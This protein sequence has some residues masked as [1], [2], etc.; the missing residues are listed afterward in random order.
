MPAIAGKAALDRVVIHFAA[1]VFLLK[2]FQPSLKP[3]LVAGAQSADHLARIRQI[4]PP[5]EIVHP[6]GHRE[7]LRLFVKLQFQP[8]L[9]KRP[10]FRK[11]GFQVFLVLMQQNQEKEIGS[12]PL[13]VH[14]RVIHNELYRK[15][16]PKARPKSKAQKQE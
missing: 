10:D 6:L 14:S 16:R 7:Y 1:A 11:T 9:R 15:T 5:T 4:K 12:L 8:V 3:P 13:L 2:G